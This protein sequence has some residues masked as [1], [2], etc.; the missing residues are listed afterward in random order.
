MHSVCMCIQSSCRY[1][2]AISLCIAGCK[3]V[4]L[5]CVSMFNFL[6]GGQTSP[7]SS[8]SPSGQPSKWILLLPHLGQ[9]LWLCFPCGHHSFGSLCFCFA[10]FFFLLLSFW[11]WAPLNVPFAYLFILIGEECI[12]V[13]PNLILK[14]DV[15]YILSCNDSLWVLD[16][17]PFLGMWFS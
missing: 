8:V 12:R 6:R 10:G 3:V 4:G 16:R 15:F 2:Y 14:L 7:F 11:C 17:S 9:C 13:S 5:H 1:V